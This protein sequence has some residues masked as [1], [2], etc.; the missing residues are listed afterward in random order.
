MIKMAATAFRELL[1][2]F[3]R[4]SPRGQAELRWGKH[5]KRRVQNRRI[6]RVMREARTQYVRRRGVH[7][8][9]VIDAI[10]RDLPSSKEPK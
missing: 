8:R 2:M 5:R 3:K 4:L 1:E 6:K 9:C 10:L 7:D